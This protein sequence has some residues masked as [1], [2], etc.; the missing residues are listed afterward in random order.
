MFTG[1]ISLSISGCVYTLV[2]PEKRHFYTVVTKNMDESIANSAAMEKAT[3]ICKA[4]GRRVI[5][6]DHRSLYQGATDSEKTLAEVAKQNL[7]VNPTMTT[8]HDY[9]VIFRFKCDIDP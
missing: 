3:R 8:A 9:K 4:E 7:K 1:L 5:I 6:L 2:Y